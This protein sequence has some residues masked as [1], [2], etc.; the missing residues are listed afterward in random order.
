MARAYVIHPE[1]LPGLNH[2]QHGVRLVPKDFDR[3]GQ[4]RQRSAEA[5][6]WRGR[7]GDGSQ[8]AGGPEA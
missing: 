2:G 7:A 1:K 8:E 4:P 3:P 5:G 6:F